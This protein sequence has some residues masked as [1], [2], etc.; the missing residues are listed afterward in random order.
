[1]ALKENEK[2][3]RPWYYVVAAGVKEILCLWGPCVGG[4]GHLEQGNISS[5]G[6]ESGLVE[7][8]RPT[9]HARV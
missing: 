3:N 1:M 7:R 6:W 2:K 8:E 4:V 9:T 5:P